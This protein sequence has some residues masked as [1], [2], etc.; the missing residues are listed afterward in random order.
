[1]GWEASRL[2]PLWPWWVVLCRATECIDGLVKDGE[3]CD[4]GIDSR[5]SSGNEDDEE[6]REMCCLVS[7]RC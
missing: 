1:M 7:V 5:A 3:M 6:C 2:A 4:S